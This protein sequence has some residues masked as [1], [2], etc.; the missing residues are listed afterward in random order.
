MAG[1]LLFQVRLTKAF[2]V[3]SKYISRITHALE[4]IWYVHTLPIRTQVSSSLALIYH[5]ETKSTF[6]KFDANK[7]FIVNNSTAEKVEKKKKS[8][9]LVIIN[10]TATNN[11]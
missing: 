11:T 5:Y 10:L 4:P 6:L 8:Q 9:E 7:R 1:K 2:V 3:S